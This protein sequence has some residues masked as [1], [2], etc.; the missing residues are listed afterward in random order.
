[1]TGVQTCALPIFG[2]TGKTKPVSSIQ[3]G[4][5]GFAVASHEG[6]HVRSSLGC[7]P[8]SVVGLKLLVKLLRCCLS[9]TSLAEEVSFRAKGGAMDALPVGST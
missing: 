9:C 5:L 4:V 2:G 6:F 1:M 3:R 8:L 7:V